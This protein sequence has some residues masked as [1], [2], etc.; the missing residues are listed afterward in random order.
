MSKFFKK[1]VSGQN[2][3]DEDWARHL[4]ESHKIAPGMT[5]RAFASHQTH[6]G[7][8]SYELLARSVDLMNER[9]VTLID[10]A[11]GNG[12]L[13]Q[14]LLPKLGNKAHILGI[15]ISNVELEAAKATYKDPRVIFHCSKAQ[16][17]PIENNSVDLILCHMAFML[18]VPIEPVIS[19]ISRVLKS[20]GRFSAIIRGPDMHGLFGDIQQLVFQFIDTRYP[21][22]REV[23]SG[24]QRVFSQ[25]GLKQLFKPKLGFKKIEEHFKFELQ[26]NTTPED[27]WDSLMK[28]MYFTG[29]LPEKEKNQL[30]EKLVSFLKNKTNSSE[31]ISFGFPMQK[32]T[33]S[34]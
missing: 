26:I 8:N 4:I 15:D 20:Q 13:I 25:E 28:D 11:C 19:E 10:L 17:L 32:F 18:M 6:E 3:T 33:I 12:Y 29:M 9:N 34:K 22:V 16:S 5:P 1:I 14:Y 30:K 21:K 23:K 27:V 24:D 7:I 2:P 31:K